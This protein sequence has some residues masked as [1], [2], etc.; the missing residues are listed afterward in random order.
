MSLT[1]NNALWV[2]PRVLTLVAA[3]LALTVA[4]TTVR[5][6]AQ[7]VAMDGPY[8]ESVVS[9][10]VDPATSD[11]YLA[12][13]QDVL[14]ST[15]GGESWTS[16]VA[17]A[18][19]S[20]VLSLTVA[21]GHVLV[22]V[23]LRGVY[24][25][26]DD[27]V[28]WDHDQ[29]T[30]DGHT[31]LGASVVG[32]GVTPAGTYYAN[33]FRS[34]NGGASWFEM[35]VFGRSFAFL[36]DGTSLAGTLDGVHRSTNEGASWTPI[37]A[38]IEDESISWLVVDDADAIYAATFDNGI[39]R[40]TNGGA[41]WVP[42]NAG[43]PSL[44]IRGL[45]R[46]AA[47]DLV[48]GTAEDGVYTS[49]D[50][51]DSWDPANGPPARLRT[52]VA[53]PDGTL[54]TGS[55]SIG[56]HAS[57]DDGATWV[58]RNAGLYAQYLRDGE[59]VSGGVSLVAAGGSGTFRSEDEGQSWT[60]AADDLF[61]PGAVDLARAANGDVYAAT[62]DGVFVTT[63]DGLTWARAGDD[64]DDVP[65]H[66]ISIAPDATLYARGQSPILGG[67]LFRSTDAGTSWELVLE[68]ADLSI[69]AIMQ[70]STVDALGRVY[71]GGF[72]F[73]VEPVVAISADG[74]DTWTETTLPGDANAVI[75]LEPVG[76]GVFAADGDGGLFRTDDGETWTSLAAGP[77]SAITS[78]AVGPGGVLFVATPSNGVYRSDDG[79]AS[80]TGFSEGLPPGDTGTHPHIAALAASDTHLFAMTRG[81]GVH[82]TPLEDVVGVAPS[83]V[84]G[85]VGPAAPNPFRT[86]TLLFS[87]D[88]ADG[89][90]V[91]ADVY[92][93]TGRH[94]RAL[95]PPRGP[96]H[97][98]GRD[99]A[100][101]RV[102]PGTYLV[103]LRVG[104][105]VVS[106]HVTLLP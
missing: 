104:D 26:T 18:G 82:R 69:G 90:A 61:S 68:D 14:R 93:V 87:G 95:A 86:R 21:P 13:Q 45:T 72:S 47:G 2:R 75:D 51:G 9:L 28:S 106:E 60:P 78:L 84:A 67:H 58:D 52:V 102:A 98:D 15:D 53:A 73:F 17:S 66:G 80:W 6:A 10:A 23:G 32:V 43:L 56:V 40:S 39:F 12:Q 16:I 76:G 103:R 38:G 22:G 41:T 30:R 35:S 46:T 11:V 37:N 7:W 49:S 63:D 92:D 31:G 27:G 50:G 97:W 85:L 59:F 74:G 77:W 25:S 29:L 19:L 100:S 24:W 105:R 79:G 36:A 83:T 101:R 64:L 91:R 96:I 34:T 55:T 33:S 81:Q 65:V 44:A 4:P 99:G 48:V 89:V 71:V 20:N 5:A 54:Y 94:V 57:I 1:R 62:S 70:A 42:I 88:V 8:G 3:L